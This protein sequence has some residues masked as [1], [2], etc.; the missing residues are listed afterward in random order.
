MKLKEIIIS[1]ENIFKQNPKLPQRYREIIDILYH[2]FTIQ[3]QNQSDVVKIK[4]FSL[5][6]IVKVESKNI[7]SEL[8]EL[9]KKVGVYIFINEECEPVYIGLAGK[10]NGDHSLKDRLQKQLNANLTNS[11]LAK[12]IRDMEG[13]LQNDPKILNTQKKSDLKKLILI[14]STYIIVIITGLLNEDSAIKE[15][16]DLEKILIAILRPKYNK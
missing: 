7:I 12:N 8:N 13:L 16:E 3:N 10:K 15:A 11:T 4:F 6:R 9:K 2:D 1:K 14:Y 5:D